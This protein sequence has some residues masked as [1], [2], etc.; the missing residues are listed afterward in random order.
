MGLRIN[1]IIGLASL[2]SRELENKELKPKTSVFLLQCVCLCVTP[3][4]DYLVASSKAPSN[5]NLIY[6]A[7]SLELVHILA[8]N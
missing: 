4:S 2:V 8:L 7:C 5:I 6:I 1:I 3:S